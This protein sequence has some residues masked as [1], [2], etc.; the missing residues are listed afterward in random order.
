[1]IQLIVLQKL[2][3]MFNLL[4]SEAEGNQETVLFSDLRLSRSACIRE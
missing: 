2:D 1:M 3:L 4:R